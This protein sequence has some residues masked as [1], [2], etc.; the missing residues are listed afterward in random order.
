MKNSI[1]EGNFKFSDNNKVSGYI[2]GDNKMCM[3]IIA[4]GPQ[5]GATIQNE[6][7]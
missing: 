2:I 6:I 1:M 3:R 4:L 7:H 5:G